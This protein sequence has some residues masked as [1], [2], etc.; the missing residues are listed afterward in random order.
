MWSV[1]CSWLKLK[2][3]A[4]LWALANNYWYLSWQCLR[5][6]VIKGNQYPNYSMY[7]GHGSYWILANICYSFIYSMRKQCNEP[8]SQPQL[9]FLITFTIS[10]CQYAHAFHISK[11]CFISLFSITLLLMEKKMLYR[12]QDGF[13]FSHLDSFVER[14]RSCMH[15]TSR[16]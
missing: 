8:S 14:S 15:A 16:S 1:F 2:F 7:L 11:V 12:L 3:V 4:Q 13:I 9:A 6:K 5:R 10:A